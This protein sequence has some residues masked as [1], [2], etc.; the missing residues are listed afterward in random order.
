[1]K[2]VE[3]LT[4]V[5]RAK[6]L[7]E[8]LPGPIEDYL[9]YAKGLASYIQ[10]HKA[11]LGEAWGD[12]FYAFEGWLSLAI[13]AEKKIDQYFKKL[14]TSSR[15]FSDQLFEGELAFWCVDA[16]MKYA[17]QCSDARFKHLAKA[18]FGGNRERHPGPSEFLNRYT[19]LSVEAAA[20]IRRVVT[21]LKELV[22]EITGAGQG[23]PQRKDYDS[24]PDYT[25]FRTGRHE[26]VAIT[27]LHVEGKDIL[28]K[29]IFK[30][31][32]YPKTT[33]IA[34]DELDNTSAIH[35]ADYLFKRSAS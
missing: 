28:L 24:L 9:Q 30:G 23:E 31:D 15:L 13:V 32:A 35:L 33:T 17:D 3:L 4:N 14:T 6:L 12:Q 22:F 25:F 26:Q 20:F 10:T 8:L 29:G 27:A 21:D 18:L 16:L 2:H 7:H 5:E 1:M 11:E 19:T 34:L